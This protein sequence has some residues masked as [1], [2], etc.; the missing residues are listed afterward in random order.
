LNK[1]PLLFTPMFRE[2]EYSTFSLTLYEYKYVESQQRHKA[3]SIN[4]ENSPA[5]SRRPGSNPYLSVTHQ[6]LGLNP[7]ADA[8]FDLIT[9]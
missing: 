3:T 5:P 4:F 1:L 9:V 2:A 8:A 7:E 6:L